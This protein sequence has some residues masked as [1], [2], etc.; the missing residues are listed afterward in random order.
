MMEADARLTRPDVTSAAVSTRP[1][2]FDGA[3]RATQP[4]QSG[5]YELHSLPNKAS[6]TAPAGHSPHADTTL[7]P[8]RLDSPS[9]QDETAMSR[10]PLLVR[11]SPAQGTGSYGGLPV[12]SVSSSPDDSDGHVTS[13]LRRGKRKGKSNL[14][15]SETSHRKTRRGSTDHASS[16]SEP[17]FTSPAQR[18]PSSTS[19]TKDDDLDLE[20]RFNTG[21]LPASLSTTPLFETLSSPT[22]SQSPASEDDE[23]E[24]DS[25]DDS[26]LDTKSNGHTASDNSPYAQVRA[27]VAA[28][29]DFTLSIN[30]PRMW[31]LSIFF[32]ILG[33]STNLFFSLR[34]PSVSITPVIA[35]LL[36]HPLGLL[37]DQLLK[38][39]YDPE[40]HFEN[41][42]LLSRGNT[43]PGSLHNARV[44]ETSL[45]RKTRFRLWL[46][47]GRWNLKE[48]CCVY[49]SS[50]VSFGFAFATDVSICVRLRSDSAQR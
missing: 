46:A 3:T 34:Y 37:W 36:V 47:Q 22:S 18:Q 29:D 24:D 39:S 32:A 5:S 28:S 16:Q 13:F 1:S 31:I 14:R 10:A 20:P 11:S 35:L 38:R 43:R 21:A 48:H 23:H 27:A 2:L 6:N 12:L 42:L 50:N 15:H 17:I 41:G 49:I 45:P 4:T 33:S 8:A 44:L 40:E 19:Y 7:A 9:H 26:L 25:S 30:T